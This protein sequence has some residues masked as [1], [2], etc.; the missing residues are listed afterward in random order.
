VK[1]GDVDAFAAQADAT[2]ARYRAAGL[3]PAADIQTYTSPIS[4]LDRQ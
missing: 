4:T 1:A 3:A 2:F